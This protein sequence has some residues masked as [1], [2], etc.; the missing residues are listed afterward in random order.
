[1]SSVGRSWYFPFDRCRGR[2]WWFIRGFH[3]GRTD[4]RTEC[5]NRAIIPIESYRVG[6][7]ARE[8]RD[9]EHG[10][11]VDGRWWIADSF[12]FR[13][14]SVTDRREGDGRNGAG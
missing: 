14:R 8:S 7:C 12:G 3:R 11:A 5:S 9:T 13:K 6:I 10:G 4:E 1:M 2:R